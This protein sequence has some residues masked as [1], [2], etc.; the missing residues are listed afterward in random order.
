METR[1][2]T[3]VIPLVAVAEPKVKRGSSTATDMPKPKTVE[4][5]AKPSPSA[6][7][8]KAQE[9]A[10]RDEQRQREIAM[11]PESELNVMT[12]A[13]TGS[14]VL[15]TLDIQSGELRHQFPNNATLKSRAIARYDAVQGAPTIKRI[16]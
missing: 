12:H 15:Q 14:L 9:Q 7:D 3:G 5:V 8:F 1:A 11:Q 4:E 16:A 10:R 13:A 6:S 2:P